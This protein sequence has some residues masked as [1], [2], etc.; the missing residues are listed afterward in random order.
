MKQRAPDM[1]TI[2][3]ASMALSQYWVEEM[4]ESPTSLFPNKSTA[5]ILEELVSPKR[6]DIRSILESSD[7]VFAV[8][9]DARKA[10]LVRSGLYAV[11]VGEKGESEARPATA[12]DVLTYMMIDDAVRAFD[13][14]SPLT[15]EQTSSWESL[16]QASN[17]VYRLIALNVFKRFSAT[18]EQAKAFYSKYLA[19]TEPGINQM[20]TENLAARGDDW[21]FLMLRQ[22]QAKIPQN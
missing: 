5:Q 21:A 3:G 13:L 16:A 9:P 7:N 20:L 11:L 14:S 4:D 18:P 12:G 10:V 17:P 15:D 19:E 6:K 2:D 22:V 1:R 8:N